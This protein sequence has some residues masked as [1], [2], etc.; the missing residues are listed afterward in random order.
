MNQCICAI[1]F[2]QDLILIVSTINE[3]VKETVQLICTF[4][5]HKDRCSLLLR[6]HVSKSDDREKKVQRIE[7]KQA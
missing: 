1:L 4:K 2:T 6:I 7:S 5:D 3:R